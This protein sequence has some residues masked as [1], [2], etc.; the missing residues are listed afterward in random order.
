MWLFDKDRSRTSHRAAR[1]ERAA[2]ARTR[3]R[4]RL[5]VVHA[6]LSAGRRARQRGRHRGRGRQPVPRL[7][8]RHRRHRHRALPSRGRRRHPGPGRQAAPHV[9]AP[10]STTRR[11][12]TWPSGSAKLAPGPS[13]KK[14]FFTNSGAEALEA[15]L[16]LARWHTERSRVRRVLRGVPRPHLR[17]HVA[18]R[19]EARPSPRLLA[20]GAGHP[21]RRRSR[22]AAPAAACAD[23]LRAASR[24]IEETLLQADRPAGGGGRHLRRADP[25]R[26]RL[27]RRRRRASC[28]RCGSC[29]TSTA[30]CSS[31]TRCSRGMGR[32][33]KMFAVE[34]WGVEPDIIC[35]AKGIASGMPLGAIIA[36]ADVMDWP[37]RQPR[38]HVRRQPGQLPGGPGDASTCSN[39]S[40]WPTPPRAAS[41]SATACASWRDRHDRPG[42]R[43]RPGPDDG[44][45]R[46]RPMTASSTR[47]AARAVIQAAFQPRAAAARLRRDR[48]PLLPAACA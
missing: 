44:G 38:Q 28:R 37:P 19:L 35:L 40:T 15:A 9:A 1:A 33:G 16:K 25:G 10:T 20:A 11:R 4:V 47:R 6:R 45:G 48:R 3:H 42:R 39:A 7:H 24:E 34:H 17:G 21:P 8:R 31:P 43:P 22:A 23:E 18:V 29:A 36:K 26:G 30:S 12:S 13:P 41:N 2:A 46:R 27:P 32:T 14:V 5:A